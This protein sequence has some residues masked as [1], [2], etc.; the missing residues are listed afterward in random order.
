MVYLHLL[1]SPLTFQQRVK[2]V[3]INL[4]IIIAGEEKIIMKTKE[5]KAE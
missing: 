3:A 1:R 5:K 2:N 4:I